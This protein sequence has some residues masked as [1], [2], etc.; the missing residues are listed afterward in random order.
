ML[1]VTVATVLLASGCGAHAPRGEADVQGFVSA[2][3]L[4]HWCASAT[5]LDT[6]ACL[7]YLRGSFD[8][9]ALLYAEHG[10][11]E[12]RTCV[13]ATVPVTELRANVRAAGAAT[14]ADAREPAARMLREL[15][16]S[17]YPCAEKV[18]D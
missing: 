13:P 7:S 4:K 17:R 14:D 2:A 18:A 9:Q 16:R 10:I 5:P 3:L 6:E 11:D 1:A 12:G 15:W 8:N